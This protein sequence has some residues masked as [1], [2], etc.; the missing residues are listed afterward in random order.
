MKSQANESDARRGELI[1]LPS[2]RF[3]TLSE[4]K[5]PSPYRLILP[6]LV[7]GLVIA[8]IFLI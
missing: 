7:I 2:V 5:D 3:Y 4:V 8:A 1:E 6:I